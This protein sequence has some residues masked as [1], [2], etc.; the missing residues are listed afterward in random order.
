MWCRKLIHNF[1]V[2]V[3]RCDKKIGNPF[4]K[5]IS[6]AQSYGKKIHKRFTNSEWKI[7]RK[8][9]PGSKTKIAHACFAFS[10]VFTSG[11]LQSFILFCTKCYA[12]MAHSLLRKNLFRKSREQTSRGKQRKND[13]KEE[14]EEKNKWT[15][16]LISNLLIF[17][18]LYVW[19][20]VWIS[21]IY[22]RK[23]THMKIPYEESFLKI[24]C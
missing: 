20:C 1:L 2:E 21:S 13:E 5:P 16:I 6:S 22:G 8:E 12:G 11:L 19:V 14:E 7:E 4:L 9:E 3:K 10:R 24:N 15:W 18:I 23:K 17:S